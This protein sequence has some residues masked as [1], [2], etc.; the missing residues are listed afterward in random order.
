M[1]L[2]LVADPRD[3]RA[4]SHRRRRRRPWQPASGSLSA[5]RKRQNPEL[6]KVHRSKGPPAAGQSRARHAKGAHEE[7][8]GV[9]EG[10]CDRA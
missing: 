6:D 5:P 4:L 7:T 9:E 8:R 1:F 3:P 10:T 2:K